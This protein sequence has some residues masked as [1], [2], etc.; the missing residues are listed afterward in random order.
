MPAL[1]GLPKLIEQA[2]RRQL[3]E[4][5]SLVPELNFFEGGFTSVRLAAVRAELVAAGVSAGLVDFFRYPTLTEFTAEMTARGGGSRAGVRQPPWRGRSREHDEAAPVATSKAVVLVGEQTR[6]GLLGGFADAARSNG[7]TPM[8]I[9]TGT[10]AAR[11][12]AEDRSLFASVGIVTDIHDPAEVARCAEVTVGSALEALVSWSDS[13]IPT[14]AAASELLGLTRTP[15]DGIL[16]CRNK[17]AMR[18]RLAEAGLPGP[19]FALLSDDTDAG[20][21]G[22]AVGLPAIVKPVNGSGSCLVRRVETLDELAV[23]YA[24]ARAAAP[25][26]DNGLLTHP[27]L[28]PDG[29]PLDATRQFL[30]ESALRG[31]EYDAEIVVREH[32]VHV[33]LLVEVLIDR[34]SHYGLGYAYPPTDLAP[35]REPRII[36]AIEAAVHALGIDNTT[37]NITVIDDD[38]LGPV[39]VEV[40]AGRVGC[41]LISR[42]VFDLTGV[43]TPTQHLAVATGGTPPQPRLPPAGVTYAALTLLAERPGQ[44]VA[45]HGL[46]ALRA[47]PKVAFAALNVKPGDTIAEHGVTYAV[48]AMVR[49]FGDVAGLRDLHRQ[50]AELVRIETRTG[51]EP[52]RPC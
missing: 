9:T 3:P 4:G 44:V 17:Y 16:R 21:V 14:A 50:L 10:A 2:F 40:N 23:A 22:E 15:R 31:A 26:V 5:R 48:N 47:H 13:V 24:A 27:V 30:V 8:L 7:C 1:R 6:S 51:P 38:L 45:V 25:T 39:I 41:Q 19:A 34:H 46:E 18:A 35:E 43:D 33:T 29:G 42:L 49:D 20:R 52:G 11:M 37:A 36:A 32:V 28:D 12:S